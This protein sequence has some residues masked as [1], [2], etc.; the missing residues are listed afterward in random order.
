[1][2]ASAMVPAVRDSIPSRRYTSWSRESCR[3]AKTKVNDPAA[4]GTF[5]CH[6]LEPP[7]VGSAISK[8]FSKRFWFVL[9]VACPPA[10]TTSKHLAGGPQEI[11]SFVIFSLS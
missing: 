4:V 9:H 10:P 3:L 6:R 5:C 11:S 7:L 2:A 1:M 8:Q